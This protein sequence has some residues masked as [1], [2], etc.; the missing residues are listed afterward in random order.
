MTTRIAIVAGAGTGL[1][2][3]VALTLSGLGVTV[4]AVDRSEPGL[5]ELPDD[6]HREVADATDPAVPGPLVDRIAREVGPPDALVNTIGA[7]ELGDALSV[8]P[9][10]LRLMID[11]NLGAAL[12]LTQAVVPHMQQNGG[13][14]IV[15]VTSRP[16]IE[17]SPGVA[18][19]A[20]AKAALAHL[21]R[22]LNV[23][24]RSSGIRVNAVAPQV[25]ATAKNKATFPPE[26]LVGAVEPKAIADIIA[27]L[28]SDAAAPISG[29]IVPAYG[30]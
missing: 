28:A 8:T 7:F 22:I 4:V 12:W 20:T 30:G 25:I 3:A 18:A 13:G 29:A 21:T 27:F 23:E 11:V 6:I 2:Q 16:G 5:K 14:A 9:Q 26:L 24:L 10:S 19:Y 15:Y 17:P 1:G